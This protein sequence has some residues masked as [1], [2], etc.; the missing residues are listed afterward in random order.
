M[1]AA[2]RPATL[3]DAFQRT[4]RVA[5]DAV[6]LRTVGDTQTMT[7]RDY[8]AR[9][10]Q[11]AAGLGA[12]G[13]G[14]GDTVSLMM[15]NRI[16]F[17]PLE[18]AAQHVG[19]TSFSVYNTST[20]ERLAQV[21][22]NTTTRLVFCEHRYVE[23][24]KAGGTPIDVIVCIDGSPDGTISVDELI[25]GG[26]ADFDFEA[27]WRAV[28]PDDV[29]TLIHTSGTTGEPKAVEATH[30]SLLFEV[31]GLDEV[32][33]LRYGDRITSFLP[34]AHTVDRVTALYLHEAI[35][36][37]VTVVPDS[38]D[39]ITALPDVRP[40]VW[41]GMPLLREKLRAGIE[42]D[43]AARTGV[44]RAL[45]DWALGAANTR[46][47]A[48]LDG[49]RPGVGDRVQY[50][51][52]DKLVLGKIRAAIGLDRAKWLI[53]GD[54]P[55]PRETLAFFVGLG[56]PMTEVWGMSELCGIATVNHPRDAVLGSVGRP[57]PGLQTEVAADGEFLVRGPLV[58]RG[59][60][61]VPGRT[62]EAID[63][64]GWL[65][66]G[67]IAT[68]DD[69]GN[70]WIIDRKEEL[71]TNAAGKKISPCSIEKAIKAECNLIGAMTTVGD[72]RPFNTALIVLD[73]ETA[74][75]Y[76]ARNGLA[77]A[78][79]Q[80]LAAD[81]QV[82]ARIATGVGRGNAKLSRAE[83]VE[84]F[85]VLPVFW[86]PGGDEMTLTMKL[87]RKR[88]AQKYAV[89]IADLYSAE[90]PSTVHEPNPATLPVGR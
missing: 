46:A 16:E 53:S 12:L 64:D 33:G 28:R 4:A 74:G 45:G 84:R 85:T 32:L 14:R 24:I 19:A 69:D 15:A 81:V 22:A 27:T 10:R 52:A 65:H 82:I 1:P 71:I 66:T 37:L 61:N 25:A 50:A 42:A 29:A 56:L 31:F 2:D 8:A 79:A 20:A 88:I 47:H 54:A 72:A 67:D 43:V 49:S 34:T 73:A 76:A 36:A 5:P 40:T 70:V 18:V 26:S 87:K 80:A 23:R 60:R 48:L 9:V 68:V 39:I 35:G 44:K 89:D 13:V 75:A 62:A 7:W 58:M 86:E 6:A 55:I 59:Y 30:T 11:V 77:D 78:S 17:Y 51:L 83:R 57:L 3:P 63:A 38:A 41:G 21:F 90:P